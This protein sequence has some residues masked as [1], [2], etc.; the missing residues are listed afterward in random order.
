MSDNPNTAEPKKPRRRWFQFRLRTMLIVVAVV[1]VAC[2]NVGRESSIVRER[3]AT[4]AAIRNSGGTVFT[5]E[6]DFA[7]A[8]RDAGRRLSREN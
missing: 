7:E 3:R 6:G 4:L 1:G 2:A 5:R 8:D